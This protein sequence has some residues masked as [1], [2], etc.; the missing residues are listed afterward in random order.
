MRELQRQIIAGLTAA[1]VFVILSLVTNFVLWF[2]FI[3]TGAL[4]LGIYLIIPRKKEP[5]EV[6]AAPGVTQKQLNDAVERI[7]IYR[8]RFA[9]LA[10]SCSKKEIADTVI[11]IAEILNTI[12]ENFKTHPSNVRDASQFL[13]LYLVRSFDIVSQYMRLADIPLQGNELKQISTIEETIKRIEQGFKDFYHQCLQNNLTDLE[14]KSETFK[15]II[16]MDSPSFDF[17]ERSRK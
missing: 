3:I 16:D 11:S 13:D 1:G 15:S 4:G 2:N 12:T 10:L 9:H 7:D 6:E 17:E 14:V 5:H 8:E